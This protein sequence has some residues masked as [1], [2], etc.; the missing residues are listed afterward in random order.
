MF[1][2][3]GFKKCYLYYTRSVIFL[4]PVYVLYVPAKNFSTV[5]LEYFFYMRNAS[6][7]FALETKFITRSFTMNEGSKCCKQDI[8]YENT[9]IHII[10]LSEKI[11]VMIQI[12]IY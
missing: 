6:F 10:S 7:K 8:L 1:A 3:T 9:Y 11:C 12:I 4:V 5:N 2:E